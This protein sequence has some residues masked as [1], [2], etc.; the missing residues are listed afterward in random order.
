MWIL[1][2]KLPFSKKLNH[3]K[4]NKA[5]H[6][7]SASRCCEVDG[8]IVFHYQRQSVYLQNNV[9]LKNC[10]L[11]P[12]YDYSH[13]WTDLHE[14]HDFLDHVS[15][16]CPSCVVLGIPINL[17]NIH[18][19]TICGPRTT[20]GVSELQKSHSHCWSNGFH[21]LI[22]GSFLTPL[23][24]ELSCIS[25]E[26]CEINLLNP[27]LKLYC[28]WHHCEQHHILLGPPDHHNENKENPVNWENWLLVLL[29]NTACRGILTLESW[30]LLP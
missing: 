4:W 17:F 27:S 14:V 10:F 25:N 19:E 7:K 30:D 2:Y 5:K 26:G 22:W 24:D 28:F 1:H 3:R 6:L 8:F 15:L 20:Q 21:W 13:E 12:V 9:N 16:F 18:L 29:I 11:H 23:L